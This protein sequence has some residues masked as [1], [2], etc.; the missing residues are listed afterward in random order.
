MEKACFRL[1]KGSLYYNK[2]G[3]PCQVC[4]GRIKPHS[5]RYC[6]RNSLL[7]LRQKSVFSRG[8]EKA[9]AAG[10][11]PDTMIEAIGFRSYVIPRIKLLIVDHQPA[12]EQIQLFSPGTFIQWQARSAYRK[13]TSACSSLCPPGF[14]LDVFT[15]NSSPADVSLF[16][17]QP[18]RMTRDTVG[19]RGDGQTLPARGCSLRQCFLQG[20]DRQVPQD[21]RW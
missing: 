12:F 6:K 9:G 5:S 19:I 2:H 16:L 17:G 20:S 18:R 4:G 1:K 14:E 3:Q 11:A 8:Q 13:T 15:M 10:F 7:E 21:V